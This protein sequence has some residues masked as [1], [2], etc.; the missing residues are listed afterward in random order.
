LSDG[1]DTSQVDS[2]FVISKINTFSAEVYNIGLVGDD[3]EDQIDLDFKS[4]P[5]KSKSGGSYQEVTK[6]NAAD[7]SVLFSNLGK[8][9]STG[10]AKNSGTLPNGV[11]LIEGTT[12]TG[13]ITIR[14]ITHT[15]TFTR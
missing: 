10:Y 11:N 1:K 8:T 12:Y 2:N 3:A 15:F 9:T 7:L 13:T 6:A 5:N 14:G 4:M